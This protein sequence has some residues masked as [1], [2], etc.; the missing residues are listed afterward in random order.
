MHPH[1]LAPRQLWRAATAAAVILGPQEPRPFHPDRCKTAR[2]LQGCY[3]AVGWQ[4]GQKSGKRNGVMAEGTSKD[5]GF[6]L[7]E[8]T[9][10][11]L[12][13]AIKTGQTTCVAVVQ[14]YIERVRAYNGPASALVTENGG[15]VPEA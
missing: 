4:S 15:D 11:D 3:S 13:R 1:P 2:K 14:R 5:Q 8:A 12:H 9:I 7:E 6:R 10:D